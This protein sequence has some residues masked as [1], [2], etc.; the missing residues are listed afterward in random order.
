MGERTTPASDLYSLGVVA[1]E[2]LTGRR[3]F[4][5]DSVAAEAAAHVTGELPSV[6]DVNPDV[7]CEVD[8]VFAKALAKHPRERYGS[9]AEFVAALRGALDAAAG[10]TARSTRCHRRLRRRVV[11]APPGS[12]RL[13]RRCFSPVSAAASRTPSRAAIRR[14]VPCRRRRRAS[15]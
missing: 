15:P 3:P 9:C 10:P 6:C 13:W 5:G 4:E 14:S 12:C 2:L 8:P 7:P 11:A 1:F